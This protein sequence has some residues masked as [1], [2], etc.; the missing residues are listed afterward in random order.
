MRLW[1][2]TL[3]FVY[4]YNSQM[5]HTQAIEVLR[6]CERELRALVAESASKGDYSSVLQLTTLAQAIAELSIQAQSGSTESALSVEAPVRLN[7][8]DAKPSAGSPK[9]ASSDVLYPK[10][11]KKGD[12]LVKVGWSKRERREY[13]HRAPMPVVAAVGRALKKVG[14]KGRLFNGGDL[15]PL[16]NPED[17]AEIPDYQ[18]YVALAWM[19]NLG[20]V[21]Q[22]GL[23]SGYTLNTNG[24]IDGIVSAAWP[25][26]GE[27]QG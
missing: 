22:R 18:A 3:C 8:V 11:F 5:K 21:K 14:A 27:W 26:L 4:V 23:R 25:K 1:G 9:R 2:F 12:E 7:T 16:K 17:S 13:H 24:A 19:K 6:T 15:L 20:V 10:F